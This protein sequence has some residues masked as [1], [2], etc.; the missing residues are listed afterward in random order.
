MYLAQCYFIGSDKQIQNI[1]ISSDG[2]KLVGNLTVVGKALKNYL[3]LLPANETTSF[4][5]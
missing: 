4:I 1:Q 3:N 5:L 2:I